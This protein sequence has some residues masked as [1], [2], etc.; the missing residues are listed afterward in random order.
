MDKQK[1]ALASSDGI[2]VNKHF[3][4]AS[5]FYIYDIEEG[6]EPNY[7]ETRLVTPICETGEHDENKL[8]ENLLSL[9][10]CSNIIAVRI[11]P[12]ARAKA[13]QMGINCFEIPGLIPQAIDKLQ[14][15]I[16]L[17]ELLERKLQ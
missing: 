3:G 14:N 8:E 15:Y 2:V 7:I 11:G 4:R 6:K 10:D 17:Q 1:I 5:S 16:K 13:E 12:G 9:K